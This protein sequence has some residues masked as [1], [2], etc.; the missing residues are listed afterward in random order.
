MYWAKLNFNLCILT[1]MYIRDCGGAGNCL[2]HCFASFVYLIFKILLFIDLKVYITPGVSTKSDIR[3]QFHFSRFNDA[4]CQSEV[5]EQA[6]E[7]L[8]QNRDQASAEISDPD[9]DMNIDE[10]SS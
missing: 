6:A 10:V 7:W 1:G 8:I 2:Y 5:R 4:S 3:N 9:G